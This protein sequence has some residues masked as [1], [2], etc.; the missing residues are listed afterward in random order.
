M[1]DCG[2][3]HREVPPEMNPVAIEPS[4]VPL[5]RPI[6]TDAYDGSDLPFP[7]PL[8]DPSNPAPPIPGAPP[9]LPPFP[10]FPPFPPR[11]PAKARDGAVTRPSAKPPPPTTST[12]ARAAAI[13][14]FLGI[15]R[16]PDF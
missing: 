9:T 2:T 5:A 10:P 13:S 12:P 11:N 4:G 1:C 14:A 6:V 15:L 3:G 7:G 8:P 16:P